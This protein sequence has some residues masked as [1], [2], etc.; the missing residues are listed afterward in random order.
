MPTRDVFKVGDKMEILGRRY[1]VIAVTNE[2][3]C[4]RPMPVGTNGHGPTIWLPLN[5]GNAPK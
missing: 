5:W 1:E 3:V 4:L 2:E